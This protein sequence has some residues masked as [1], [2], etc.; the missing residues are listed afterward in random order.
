MKN[1]NLKKF[2]GPENSTV[3]EALLQ[4]RLIYDLKMAAALRNYDLRIYEPDIDRDG[5]DLILD[6]GDDIGRFQVKSIFESETLKWSIRKRLLRLPRYVIDKFS[7]FPSPETNGLGGG[8]I[9]IE[10][11]SYN[12][13]ITVDYWYMDFYVIFAM[14]HGLVRKSNNRPS[15]KQI[16]SFVSKLFSGTGN[17]K[18]DI[19]KSFLIKLKGREELLVLMGMHSRCDGKCWINN[20]MEY[21]K[22][23][24]ANKIGHKK[25][26]EGTFKKLIVS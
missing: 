3:R 13:N 25:M 9:L 15:N 8:F 2:L 4:H 26:I 17:E 21:L 11:K 10:A 16:D 20:L 18:I 12:N 14:R 22:N 5:Y 7:F 6:D 1:N 24:G 19:R 23:K